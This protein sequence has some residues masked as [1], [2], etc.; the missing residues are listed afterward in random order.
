MLI[1]CAAMLTIQFLVYFA[2]QPVWSHWSSCWR[3]VNGAMVAGG[4][5]L[6]IVGLAWLTSDIQQWNDW[7]HKW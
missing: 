7:H 4:I 2:Y 5:F 6:F 1:I 3:P